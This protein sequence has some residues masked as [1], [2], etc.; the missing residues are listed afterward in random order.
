MELSNFYNDGFGWV[1]RHCEAELS[2]GPE[3][4]GRSRLLREGEGETRLSSAALA[5]WTDATRTTLVCPRCGR[6]EHASEPPA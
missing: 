2:E 1:C 3:A 6:T 5:K 4:S